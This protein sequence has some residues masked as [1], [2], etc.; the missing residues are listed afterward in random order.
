V[1]FLPDYGADAPM[2]RF[3]VRTL[4]APLV[5]VRTVDG[6]A[7]TARVRLRDGAGHARWTH[8]FRGRSGVTVAALPP[9]AGPSGE[10]RLDA[11]VTDAL[12]RPAQERSAWFELVRRGAARTWRSVPR[13][14]TRVALTFD[15]GWDATSA[16]SIIATLRRTQAPATLFIN[17]YAYR[18][19]D[20]LVA[21]VRT[22]LAA[23][24]VTLGNHTADHV[25]LTR[26]PESEIR[27]QL[28]DDLAYV[29]ET[30]HRSSLSFF[31]PPYGLANAA[32]RRIAGGLG[33][34][35]IMLW[36]VDGKDYQGPPPA[37]VVSRIMA[38]VQDGAVI[39]MHLSRSGAAALPTVIAR[40]RARGYRI[41]GLRDLLNR[42]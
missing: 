32:V 16:L 15:D 9:L 38:Q 22:A 7:W 31:R 25:D 35:D 2:V 23:D 40:L 36:S 26:V 27:A 17:G 14:G 33:Y 24:A 3:D 5:V 10:Y 11:T 39:L 21:A 18:R 41:V 12:G 20:A 19:S 37:T 8:T 42:A 34:T 13:A 1:A 29:H 4:T 30:F 6:S 28:A